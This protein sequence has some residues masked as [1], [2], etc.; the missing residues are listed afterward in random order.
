MITQLEMVEQVF[1][2][3]IVA[4]SNTGSS[5]YACILGLYCSIFPISNQIEVFHDWKNKFDF[6]L[7]SILQVRLLW[8]YP[9][10]V[11]YV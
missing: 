6:I 5:D 1:Y 8:P 4:Y 10:L 3:I 9:I 7:I 2:A 11:S